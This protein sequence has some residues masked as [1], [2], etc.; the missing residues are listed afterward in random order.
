MRW[1]LE[2]GLAFILL[3][4]VGFGLT[5]QRDDATAMSDEQTTRQAL[6]RLYER[7]AYHGALQKSALQGYRFPPVIEPA[8][9]GLELPINQTLADRPWLDI[10][11]PGDVGE[12]P[13]DPLALREDQAGFWYNPNLGVFRARVPLGKGG[14]DAV[15]RYN[16]LNKVALK[17]LPHDSDPSR[18]PLAYEPGS[19][20]A[21]SYASLG[22]RYRLDPLA[23]DTIEPNDRQA[24]FDPAPLRVGEVDPSWGTLAE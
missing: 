20:P 9:F 21:V 8:W 5:Q 3:L 7:S 14:S 17:A 23:Y 1:I 13:P 10:A 6:D 18:R 15:D 12:H 4:V 11:P 22:Y 2:I 19:P 24:A 16:R